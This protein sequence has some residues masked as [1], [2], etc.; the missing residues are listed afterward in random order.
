MI[1]VAKRKIR[2]VNIR[3]RCYAMTTVEHL[4]L[5]SLKRRLEEIY[6]ELKTMLNT[7]DFSEDE[8]DLDDL[9]EI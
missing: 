4:K 9:E 2:E 7:G 5:I 8:D 3:R 1:A 6:Y